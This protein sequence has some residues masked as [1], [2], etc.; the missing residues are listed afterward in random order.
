MQ[1][2]NSV[3]N[4]QFDGE[5]NACLTSICVGTSIGHAENASTSVMQCAIKLIFKL[6]T[7]YTLPAFASACSWYSM[8]YKRLR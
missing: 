7:I 3:Q 4:L 5:V 2:H 6:A 8:Y 1:L